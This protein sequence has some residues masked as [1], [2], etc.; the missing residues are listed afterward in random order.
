[1]QNI[2]ALINA[3]KSTA[4][5][6]R[7]CDTMRTI[8]VIPYR[9]EA[10]ILGLGFAPSLA[11]EC[12]SLGRQRSRWPMYGSRHV[13][14]NTRSSTAATLNIA[15]SITQSLVHGTGFSYSEECD[16]RSNDG[17][18]VVHLAAGRLPVST[19]PLKPTEGGM[20]PINKKARSVTL[21]LVRC[22]W[23]YHIVGSLADWFVVW[24]CIMETA[25]PHNLN[26]VPRKF[27]YVRVFLHDCSYILQPQSD[28]THCALKRR[29]LHCISRNGERC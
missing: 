3:Y 8:M 9:Q 6:I 22:W 26:V 23:Q 15:L 4:L 12:P 1:M 29:V 19:L 13:Y 7:T 24:T 21:L 17:F 11:R 20:S 27:E 16:T 28:E 2:R 5:P 14:H 25:N 10:T 18:T